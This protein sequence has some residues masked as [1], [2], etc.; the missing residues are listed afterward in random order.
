MAI[1]TVQGQPAPTA[2][3]VPRPDLP[4]VAGMSVIMYQSGKMVGWG[5]DVNFDE[6]FHLQPVNTLGFHGPRGFV[7]T[8]Y[9]CSLRIGGFLLDNKED[10]N[11]D[12]PT[13][14]TILTSG[15]IDFQL[16]HKVK[17]RLL[18]DIRSCKCGSNS[19]NID[20]ALSRKNTRWE[21]T[22]VIPY[23]AF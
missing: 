12:V 7:S 14:Q 11:L 20:Q 19:V 1:D 6:D 15:L 13:R 17:G 23:Y 10:D 5:T 9:S 21:C 8:N 18:Y 22:E 16:I 2:G 3:F 4:V